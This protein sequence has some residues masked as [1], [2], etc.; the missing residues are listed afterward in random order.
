[1]FR[2]GSITTALLA[3]TLSAT[4][5]ACLATAAPAD[6][7]SDAMAA[8]DRKDRENPPPAGG[9]VFVGSSSIGGWNLDRYFPD[10][11]VINRGFGGS[12]IIDSVNHADLLVIRH[13]PRVVVFY[14]GD[15]DLAAGKTPEEVS[16]DFRAFV[17]KLHA[18][19][20]ETRILFIGIKPSI[21]RWNLIGNVR[22]TNALIRGFAEGDDRLGFVDVDGPMLGWDGRPR[23]ELLAEDGLH[24]TAKGYELWT[25][26]VRP[27][28]D[29]P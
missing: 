20:P 3:V 26:L 6:Q 21:L 10:L 5:M 12:Q 11:P 23:K 2:A 27:F 1:M 16:R 18:S 19:V 9:I 15:N 24:M 7:W 22:E 4:T 17:A 8:F 29:E 14:A 25:M 13:K 28:L